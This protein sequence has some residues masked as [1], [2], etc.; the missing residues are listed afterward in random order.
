MLP[1][2]FVILILIFLFLNV[3]SINI[4]R[5]LK[6]NSISQNCY[7]SPSNNNLNIFHIIIARFMIQFWPFGDFKKNL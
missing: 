6:A 5:N 3:T 4:I 2:L 1:K 7:L